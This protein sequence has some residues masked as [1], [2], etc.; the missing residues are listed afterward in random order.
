M[1]EHTEK[2]KVCPHCGAALPEEAAF[3]PY[4][5]QTVNRRSHLKAPAEGWRRALRRALMVLMPLLLVG[6]IAAGYHLTRP[7]TYE[8][9]GEVYYSDLSGTYHLFLSESASL[10]EPVRERRQTA[11]IGDA[12][13]GPGLLRV[14][15]ADTGADAGAAFLEKIDRVTAEFPTIEGVG[16][17]FACTAPAPHSAFPDVPL[18]S[19]VDY[20]LETDAGAAA[21]MVWTIDMKNGDTIR[22][23]LDYICAPLLTENYYPEDE[24]MGTTEEL[25]ALIDEIA[26]A[27]DRS[28][29][30]NIYLP[31]VTYD[32][33][34]VLHGRAINLYGS[35]G[36]EQRTVFTG[37]IQVEA[38]EDG[39]ISYFQDIDFRGN[40]GV[41]LSAAANTRATDCLFTGWDTALYGCG[42]AWINSIGCT[43][44]D[45]GVGLHFNST[46]GSANH[47]LYN[48]NVFHNNATA[49]L[50]ENVPTDLPLDFQGS[51]FSGNGTDIDNRCGQP[52]DLSGAAFQ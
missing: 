45:N 50:L 30:I 5:A 43:F 34:L 35:T 49:V 15:D 14:H 16:G 26:A 20:T 12:Y 22:L 21:E 10:Q 46:E 27:E 17:N 4:C 7:Q 13:R 31:A 51:T 33:T 18:V 25:Q 39:R 48:G 47:S 40:G 9:V 44:T 41:A 8:G 23:R 24:P 52:L 3:C 28:S 36:G 37:S 42:T 11:A 19:L 38:R 2:Q 1:A 32:G 6:G 29:I